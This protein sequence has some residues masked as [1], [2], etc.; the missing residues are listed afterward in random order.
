LADARFKGDRKTYSTSDKPLTDAEMDEIAKK[1]NLGRWNFYG[2]VY[3]PEPVRQ[4]LLKVIKD[5]FLS[6]P[7]SKYYEPKDMPDNLVLQTRDKTLQGIPTTVELKWV[8]WLPNGA[9]LFFSPIAKVTG[10]DAV[11]QYEVSRR[12]CE[13]AGLDFIGT[14]VIGMREMHHIVCIV[15]DRTKAEH[16]RKAHWLITT[17]IED[18]A[19]RGWGEYRTHIAVM[20]QIAR[21][22]SFND[23]AQMRLNEK[24]KECRKSTYGVVSPLPR[25]LR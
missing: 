6:I 23:N 22:Y 13:E 14:F 19:K 21:T 5:A 25:V 8:D 1:L 16:R 17:L 9:H 4:V 20:D 2:A 18:A 11:A 12:R 24:I 3:G 7:G 15:F 10:D